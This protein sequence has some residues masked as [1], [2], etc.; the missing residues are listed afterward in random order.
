MRCTRKYCA[1]EEKLPMYCRVNGLQAVSPLDNEASELGANPLLG[2]E[3]FIAPG[4]SG[5]C[6]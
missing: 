2:D 1:A 6:C 4:K 3:F 5:I